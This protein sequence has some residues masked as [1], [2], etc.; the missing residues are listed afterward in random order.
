MTTLIDIALTLMWGPALTFAVF[1]LG[2]C[3]GEYALSSLAFGYSLLVVVQLVTGHL[4]LAAAAITVVIVALWLLWRGSFLRKR[5]CV[6]QG[7]SR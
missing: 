7:G 3:S 2:W 4:L 1:R 6:P 5:P